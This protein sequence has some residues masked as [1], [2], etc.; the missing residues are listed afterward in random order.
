M[1][2]R[3]PSL[4]TAVEKLFIAFF[5]SRND[6]EFDGHVKKAFDQLWVLQIRDGPSK[7]VWPWYSVDLDPWE[8][9]PAFSFGASLAAL[10]IGMAP[11]EYR[12]AP[13]MR[14]H[15]QDLK[16]Y[17]QAELANQPL[18]SR[19]AMLWASM[20]VPDLFTKSEQMAII[21]DVLRKQ[22][23]DGG[24]SLESL[25]PW[26]VHPD[27]APSPDGN[28]Y[29]TGFAADVLLKAGVAPSDPALLRTRDW[30]KSHPDP[31]TGAWPAVPMNKRYSAGSME[32]RFLQD[33]ATAFAAMALI[34]AGR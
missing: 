8:T 14:D 20:A 34:E 16:G 22:H 3:Y 6:P 13:E 21:D 4:F 30:L 10:A 15:I 11:A 9:P 12:N 2:A 26:A 33:A 17:M 25:G 31:K 19:L 32:E 5:L 24:W 7:G 29:A 28:S 1:D 18:H 27:A 23:R